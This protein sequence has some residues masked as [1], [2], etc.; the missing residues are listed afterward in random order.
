M[1]SLGPSA[2]PRLRNVSFTKDQKDWITNAFRQGNGSTTTASGALIQGLKGEME[3]REKAED[4]E[5]E[6][7]SKSQP[8]QNVLVTSQDIRNFLKKQELFDL[9]GKSEIEVQIY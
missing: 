9:N 4:C 3:L 5:D 7:R 6:G 2:H 1:P 8:P